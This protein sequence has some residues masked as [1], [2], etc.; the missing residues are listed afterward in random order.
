MKM[1]PTMRSLISLVASIACALLVLGGLIF[2][3]QDGFYHTDA[4][5]IAVSLVVVFGFILYRLNSV[6]Y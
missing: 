6:E 2:I 3:F 4:A 5:L 1:Y